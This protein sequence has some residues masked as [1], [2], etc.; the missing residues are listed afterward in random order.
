MKSVIPGIPY[1]SAVIEKNDYKY[2]SILTMLFIVVLVACEMTAFLTVNIKQ[3]NMPVSAI[4]CPLLFAF[5]DLIAEVYGYSKIKRVI[6]NGLFCQLIF[7]SFFAI[8]INIE[9]VT[10]SSNIAAFKVVFSNI[11][12]TNIVTFLAITSGMFINAI[13]IS[14]LKLNMNGKVYWIRTIISSC[15]SGIAINLIC[16]TLLY[17]EYNEVNWALFKTVIVVF[18]YGVIAAVIIS[19]ILSLIARMIKKIERIDTFDYNVNYNP[20]KI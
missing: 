2:L 15:S 5:S 18:L 13:I 9:L 11:M 14:K 17:L 20:F 6:W 10:F 7:G 8:L 3:I 12:R 16:Y 4:I 19:P 1:K